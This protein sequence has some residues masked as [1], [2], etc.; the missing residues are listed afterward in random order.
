MEQL[1]EK[2]FSQSVETMADL[3]AAR[4]F[5]V[6]NIENLVEEVQCSNPDSLGGEVFIW[7]SLTGGARSELLSILGND[8]DAVF[9]SLPNLCEM[10]K[11]FRNN[12]L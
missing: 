8:T 3:L 10:A 7:S 4:N 2:D 5:T 12:P 1:Y 9:E 11:F 6:P